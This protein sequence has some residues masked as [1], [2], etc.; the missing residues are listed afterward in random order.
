MADSLS[1][2]DIAAA[3]KLLGSLY[4]KYAEWSVRRKTSKEAQRMKSRAEE[5]MNSINTAILSGGS[6]DD[7]Q[8]VPKVRELMALLKKGVVSTD[9][10]VT[11]DWID[12]SR[13]A[14]AKKAAAKKAPAKK[15]A[16]KKAAGKKA[17]AKKPAAK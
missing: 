16:A 6:S 15:A 3:W 9:T 1:L 11:E 12:R 14:P 7:P 10:Y 2:A 5:L 13:K 4:E 17:A 8:L